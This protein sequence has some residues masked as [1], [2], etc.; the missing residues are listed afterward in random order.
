VPSGGQE[1]SNSAINHCLY[2]DL[3]IFPVKVK[4]IRERTAPYGH[5]NFAES[6]FMLLKIEFAASDVYNPPSNTCQS[7]EEP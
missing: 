2:V 6:S 5:Q 7:D 1:S 3:I 4:A